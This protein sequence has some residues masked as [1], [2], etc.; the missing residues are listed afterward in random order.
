MYQNPCDLTSP[1]SKL[2]KESQQNSHDLTLYYCGKQ[3]CQSDHL[4]SGIREHY[5]IH[6]ITAG[7]GKVELEGKTYNL[8][9]NYGFLCPANIK[10]SYQA[11]SD[12]PWS[13]YWIGFNGINARNQLKK[14]G[15]TANNPVYYYD[16]DRDLQDCMEDIHQADKQKQGIGFFL[17]SR[18]NQLFYL[19]AQV[20]ENN[21]QKKDEKAIQEQYLKNAINFISQNYSH[22]ISIEDIAQ[23][24]GIS[25]KYLCTLFKNFLNITT[26]Q[27]LINHRLEKACQLLKNKHLSITEVAFSV[28][29]E[30]SLVFSKAFKKNKGI[31]PSKY[32]KDML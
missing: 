11:D 13:Y 23:H 4:Y 2:Y 9:S 8:E 25:R 1:T 29:Y 14:I 24:T 20:K 32:R 31:P 17:T 15:L 19:I 3:N 22:Q 7:R 10:I 21:T 16:Q 30:N 28:G 6:Y 27:Y 5:L 26:Q 12:N 18:I